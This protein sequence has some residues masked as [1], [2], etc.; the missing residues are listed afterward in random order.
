MPS[1]FLHSLLVSLALAASA[2]AEATPPDAAQPAR[3]RAAPVL[4]PEHRDP[5][6]PVG[7]RPKT[8]EELELERAKAA[9][10]KKSVS[11]DLWD[12]ARALLRI[13]GSMRTPSGHTALI[14]GN[15]V[16]KGD[17]IALPYKGRQYRWKV[18]AITL[19]GVS[20][21]PLDAVSLEPPPPPPTGKDRP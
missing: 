19:A 12:E 3:P 6:W 13:G 10:S 18:D 2:R 15:P 9:L 7:W 21:L 14:N 16:K 4:S 1:P 11:P 8:P 20:L 17:Q 5:F